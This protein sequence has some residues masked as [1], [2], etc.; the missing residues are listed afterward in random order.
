MQVQIYKAQYPEEKNE[1][2][3]VKQK[4]EGNDNLKMLE[5]L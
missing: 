4:L 3:D 5:I 1:I 2:G